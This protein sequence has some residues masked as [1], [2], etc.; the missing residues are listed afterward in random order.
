MS[1][2]TTVRLPPD[3]VRRAKY[4]AAEQGRSLTALMEEGLRRVVD[5]SRTAKLV[6]RTLPRV[7][8]AKGGLAPGIEWDRLSAAVE[9]MDDLDYV[10]RL[11]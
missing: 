6:A 10:R 8:A 11:F 5:E 1:E 3:L 9:E 2:R 7:S 4:K